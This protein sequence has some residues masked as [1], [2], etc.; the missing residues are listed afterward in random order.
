MIRVRPAREE[1]MHGVLE[2]ELESISPPWT[3]GG[4]LREI[5]R[6]DSFFA[7][8]TERVA[9]L[10]FVILRRMAD[11]GELFQIAVRA[12]QRRRGVADLLMEAALGWAYGCGVTEIY[13][14]ARASNEAA[15]ALYKKHG[16]KQT[17]HRKEYYTDP[18]EDAVIMSA[19]NTAPNS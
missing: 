7:L 17:G 8:A 11:E 16:F 9:V 12:A 14:E 1:D 3:H 13:L 2:I 6:N 19:S 4:L 15:R 18:V 5:Y 10:G